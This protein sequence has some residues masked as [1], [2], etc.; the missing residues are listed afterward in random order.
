MSKAIAV[1]WLVS[2]NSIGKEFHSLGPSTENAWR[3]HEF[4]RYDG[5]TS[6]W[7]AAERRWRLYTI[8][9]TGTQLAASTEAPYR[10]GSIQVEQID[11]VVTP[12][13][14]CRPIL[15]TVMEETSLCSERAQS[16]KKKSQM[17]VWL[18]NRVTASASRGSS[19]NKLQNGF[20]SSVF[21]ILQ[22]G[23]IRFV[24]NLFLHICIN[25][26]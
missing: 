20:I 13:T 8:S 25:V 17:D 5:T 4:R 26:G 18:L 11:S 1:L 10:W 9:E 6:W 2:R 7:P 16:Q 15:S 12:Y 3:P 22:I 14:T 23:N 24:G 19:Q 21:R